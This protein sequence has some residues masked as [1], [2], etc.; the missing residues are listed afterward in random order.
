M[1]V[2]EVRQQVEWEQV[3]ALT[4]EAAARKFA[5]DEMLDNGSVVEVKGIGFFR[6]T[7]RYIEPEYEAKYV[8]E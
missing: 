5:E 2:Y 8:N 1:S 6:I 4:S 3:K 7:E